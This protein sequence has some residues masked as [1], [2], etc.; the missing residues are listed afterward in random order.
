MKDNV[1]IE[2]YLEQHYKNVTP[3]EF[4]RDVFP[5]GEL[6]E[7][8]KQEQG[9]YNGIAVEIRPKDSNRKTN[10]YYIH[11]D[12]K[13]VD[14]IIQS[15]YFTILAPISYAGKS[16]ESRNA[17]VIYGIA[18]DI[19][20]LEK[21]SNLI[22]YFYQQ[23]N[24]IIP[25][26][27]YT[28][29]SGTGI[30]AYYLLEEPIK[31]YPQTV[32]QLAD[33]RKALTRLIWNGYI[34]GKL[35]TAIQFESLFQ[36]FRAV[37][38]IT[39]GGGR[40]KAYKTGDRVSLNYLN[41]FV[42]EKSKVSITQY[43]KVN[44]PYE[45]VKNEIWFEEWY[46]KRVID[47]VPKGTWVC[48]QDLYYWWL[49]RIPQEAKYG[50]R[51][52][53]LMVLAIY[54]KKAGVSREQ[55]EKD[56]FNLLNTLD[57]LTTDEN[58]HFTYDDIM[59]ALEAY[60][61]NYIRFPID[62]IVELT[63]IP[64][65]KNKRNGRTQEEHC[66]Y[67]RMIKKFKIENNEIKAGGRKKGSKNKNSQKRDIIKEYQLKNPTATITECSLDTGI[68]RTTIYKYWNEGTK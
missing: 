8:G 55:L 5:L 62:S 37:G 25:Q 42:D 9:K 46:Q 59:A 21:E 6:A 22:D 53:S 32:S 50:H 27:T 28:V 41:S 4:Y 23:E 30:H 57:K 47:K 38:S 13:A 15:D 64:I 16:R 54:A 56:S 10:R 60:N 2:A 40:V 48:K 24:E 67:M 44:E 61:D 35:D 34:V 63:N 51:Y 36:G 43:Q 26:A 39:K 12:L 11:N 49:K 19:D 68:S 14:N 45:K 52:F 58:N 31:C 3:K 1:W 66:K 17:R 33:L 65:E 7:Q 20:G 18:I 29:F